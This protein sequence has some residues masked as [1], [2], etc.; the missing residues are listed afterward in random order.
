MTGSTERRRCWTCRERKIACDKAIPACLK[1]LEKGKICPGYGMKLSW[2]R[3]NNP[4]RSAQGNK[5]YIQPVRDVKSEYINVTT[6]DIEASE[7]RYPATHSQYSDSFTPRRSLEL[8]SVR[9]SELD[10]FSLFD[11]R[12]PVARL[13]ATYS[14]EDHLY[15]LL[16]RI[17]L[18]DDTP[19][20]LAPR[21]ALS[22]ISYQHLGRH[23]EAMLHQAKSLT[24]LQTAISNP[25]DMTTA[26]QTMASSMLL[27]IFETMN[28][29]GSSLNWAIFFCG[30]KK[31]AKTVHRQNNTYEGDPALI[32][33]WVF[34]HDVMYKFSIRHWSDKLEQQILLAAED[35]IVS[36][37]VFSPLR[38]VILPSLGCSLELLDVVCQI[39]EV[40][41]DRDDPHFRS[42]QHLAAIRTLELRLERLE[43]RVSAVTEDVDCDTRA[44]KK[45]AELFR[46]AAYIYLERLAKGSESQETKVRCLLDDAFGLLREL[47]VCERPW[48]LF[49][50]ALE[51]RTDEERVL[52]LSVLEQSLIQRPMGNLTITQ[53]LIHAAWIQQDLH[54]TSAIDPLLVYDTVV[55]GNRVPPSFT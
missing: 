5:H 1:C 8:V 7:D 28:F 30:T 4:S 39:V 25:I 15:Q 41:L 24:A 37:A 34:Y 3:G 10:P 55:S 43:Q 2:P 46:L 35:K 49:I 36:K 33:D 9:E 17:S 19:G 20:S 54:A 22:A 50:I 29:D 51:A 44:T 53:R 32:L 21:H 45:L 14:V 48:P 6:T 42:D 23:D 40:V 52:I 26:L 11:S 13:L 47:K 12:S 27:N 38:Q 16:A 31:I 18:S